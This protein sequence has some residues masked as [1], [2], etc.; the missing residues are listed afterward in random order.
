[1]HWCD[2]SV[3][4]KEQ[5]CLPPVY[6]KFRSIFWGLQIHHRHEREHQ[7]S[8]ISLNDIVNIVVLRSN[9]DFVVITRKEAIWSHI[10]AIK[11]TSGC[12]HALKCDN[13]L[14]SFEIYVT[15]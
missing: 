1:M 6:P 4:G 2:L 13:I 15:R 7:L 11:P 8:S 12:R 10:F 9:S 14:F 3:Q 5:L